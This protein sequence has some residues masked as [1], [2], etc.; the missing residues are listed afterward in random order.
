MEVR[1]EVIME[2]LVYELAVNKI[3]DQIRVNSCGGDCVPTMCG[4]GGWR[5]VGRK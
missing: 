2:N 4:G 5:W 3:F 1:V